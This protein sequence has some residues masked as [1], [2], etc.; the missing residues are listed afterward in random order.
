VLPAHAVFTATGENPGER[1][2]VGAM[3][4]Q[5]F[6]RLVTSI[7]DYAVLMLDARGYI[8]S[9]NT[10]AQLI[11]GYTSDE[12]IGRHISLLYPREDVRVGKPESELAVAA[13]EGQYEDRG[14]RVRK[15]G[16]PFWTSLALTA[17]RDDAG[18]IVGYSHVARD[19]TEERQAQE[20]AKQTEERFRLLVEGVKEYAIFM[21]DPE[22]HVATWNAGAERIKGYRADEIIGKHFSVFYPPEDI[23]AGKIEREIE[24]A[25][26][27]GRFEDEGWRVRKD[28]SMFWANVVI[29]ALRDE[30]DQ[31]VGFAKVTRDLTER[32]RHEEERVRLAHAL[33]AV[34]LRDE[35]LSI[36]S[37]ELKTPLTVLRLQLE[38]LHDRLR[39]VDAPSTTKLERANRASRR[40]SELVETLLDV[41][42][43]ATGRFELRRDRVD[44]AEVARESVDHLRDAAE[45]AGCD[46]RAD[47][48]EGVVGMYDRS[49]I[50]QAITNLIANAIKYAAGAP[51][52]ISL[53]R[54]EQSAW[55]EVRDHGPGLPE[56]HEDTVFERFERAAPMQNYGGL[57][58]GLYV[59]SQI[60]EAHGGSATAA[61]ASGGGACFRV[62]LPLV[63]PEG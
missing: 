63:P 35:F 37:H 29:T 33:E 3:T 10:G 15:D 18:T 53:H 16:T 36:A 13:R 40:L 52:E 46:L 47:L 57:G 7:R 55:I 59:V 31:L 39:E 1:Q 56:G 34:R 6:D 42:R 25:I 22:G 28:G 48:A 26:R 62:R 17:I 58:L 2:P 24:G 49:R 19:L 30:H 4:D 54:D 23:R 11:S 41:S 27:D 32:R 14:W 50:D 20:A 45:A 44:L 38:A 9:W 12:V 60:A 5:A 61:N 8:M 43:I 21:L 51:I